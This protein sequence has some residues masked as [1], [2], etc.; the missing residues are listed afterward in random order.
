[1]DLGDRMKEYENISRIKLVKRLPIII[2]LDGK[3][4]HT[5]TRGLDKPFDKKMTKIMN[6][7][8]LALTG[9]IQGSVFGYTQSDEISLLLHPWNN[10]ESQAWF[11]N[12]IQK[13]VSISAGYASSWFN[14]MWN[15]EFDYSPTSNEVAV[16]DSRVFVLPYEEVVNYFIWRQQDAIRN[17]VQ[18][19]GQAHFSHKQLHKKN[20]PTIKK[21]LLE[22]GI[23]WETLPNHLKF[24]TSIIDEKIDL[25]TPSF[26]LDRGY[27]EETMFPI[28]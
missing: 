27:I 12:N 19:L 9:Q 21:M 26:V 25:D 24:G 15:N 3:S 4:F 5:V 1:M 16:F 20:I 6:W 2:R 8:T 28:T 22:D 13:I 11:D 10:F 18:A 23:D 17:S 7:V 14:M